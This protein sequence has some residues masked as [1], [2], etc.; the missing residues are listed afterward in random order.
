VIIVLIGKSNL[1]YNS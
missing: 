1:I